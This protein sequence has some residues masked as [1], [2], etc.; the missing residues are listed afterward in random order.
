MGTGELSGCAVPRV[1]P[2]ANSP[3]HASALKSKSSND[4]VVDK[5]GLRADPSRSHSKR[6]TRP[7]PTIRPVRPVPSV[8]PN[9]HWQSRYRRRFP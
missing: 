9:A 8:E 2:R 7:S 6:G 5:N 4:K 1:R 3:M